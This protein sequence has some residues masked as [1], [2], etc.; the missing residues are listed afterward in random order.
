MIIDTKKNN[1]LSANLRTIFKSQEFASTGTLH[2]HWNVRGI[3][4]YW[5]VFRDIALY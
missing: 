4:W 1:A 2:T 3:A 5:V